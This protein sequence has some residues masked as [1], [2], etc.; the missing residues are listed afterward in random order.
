MAHR[1]VEPTSRYM[2]HLVSL[3]CFALLL[4]FPAHLPILDRFPKPGP[5]GLA[6]RLLDADTSSAVRAQ[7]DLHGA[8]LGRHLVHVLG[9]AYTRGRMRLGEEQ[10]SS[11]EVGHNDFTYGL[12]S[13]PLSAGSVG[14]LDLLRWGCLS[15]RHRGLIQINGREPTGG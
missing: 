7:F 12:L 8:P 14:K 15:R 10:I 5:L 9:A 4:F 6:D 1:P 11:D 3:T 2:M 13:A